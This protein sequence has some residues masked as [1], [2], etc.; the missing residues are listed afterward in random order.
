MAFLLPALADTHMQN[1]V[2]WCVRDCDVV[3]STVRV[4]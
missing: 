3:F 1:K 4:Y 2:A